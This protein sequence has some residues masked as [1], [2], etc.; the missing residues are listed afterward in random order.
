VPNKSR[1]RSGTL[2]L[3]RVLVNSASEDS[4]AAALIHKR[5]HFAVDAAIDDHVYNHDPAGQVEY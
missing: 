2:P 4:C 5:L 3:I 1:N